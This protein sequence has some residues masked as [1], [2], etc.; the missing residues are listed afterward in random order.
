MSSFVLDGGAAGATALA[1]GIGSGLK[2]AMLGEH[3]KSDA[4]LKALGSTKQ[5]EEARSLRM[6]NDHRQNVDQMIRDDPTMPEYRKAQLVALKL[7]GGEHM[8]NFSRAGEVEQRVSHRDAVMQNPALAVPVAQAH[9]ATSG[10][11][12]FDNV[13]TTGHSVNQVTGEQIVAH[14]GMAKLFQ[15]K[16]AATGGGG[17][18]LTLSQERN[19]AEI[20]AAR[21]L[22]GGMTPDEIRRR[23]AKTTDTGRENPDYDPTLSRAAT[24]AARRKIGSDAHFDNRNQASPAPVTPPAPAA[25]QPTTV[26]PVAATAATPDQDAIK[27]FNADPAMKQHKLGK[28]TPQGIEVL[29]RSGRVIGHYQ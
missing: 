18:S 28:K 9:F 11:A 1:K 6:T 8:D 19:N 17:G 26:A 12:P 24:L 22:V 7:L 16:Q 23:T 20:D 3:Y 13:G 27:R 10:K 25:A 5:A 14:P 4:Y 29:D 2:A 15:G 21:D